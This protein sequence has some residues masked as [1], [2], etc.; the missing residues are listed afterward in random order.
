MR[1]ILNIRMILITPDHNYSV[2]NDQ[3]KIR[4]LIQSNGVYQKCQ[5]TIG[6]RE[7]SSSNVLSKLFSLLP[8]HSTKSYTVLPAKSESGILKF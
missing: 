2:L 1:D 6:T 8:F 3:K 7:M 5:N 4:Q